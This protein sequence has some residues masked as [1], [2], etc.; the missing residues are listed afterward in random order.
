MYCFRLWFCHI[1]D[2]IVELLTNEVLEGFLKVGDDVVLLS[3]SCVPA[4]S[5]KV[6]EN[7][8]QCAQRDVC[9]YFYLVGNEV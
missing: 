7:V 4:L 9:F 1:H 2:L 3:E 5:H 6:R 8:R